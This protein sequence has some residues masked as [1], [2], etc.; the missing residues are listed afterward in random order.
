MALG[1]CSNEQTF[2]A[3]SEVKES[4]GDGRTNPLEEEEPRSGID[5]SVGLAFK[6]EAERDK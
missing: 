4:S 3:S 2:D 5:I 1:L 6:C